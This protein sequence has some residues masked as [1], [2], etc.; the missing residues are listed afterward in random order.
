MSS[1]CLTK[2]VSLTRS[3]LFAVLLMARQRGSRSKYLQKLI[4]LDMWSQG[5]WNNEAA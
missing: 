3:K 2:K 1:A 4:D 5:E